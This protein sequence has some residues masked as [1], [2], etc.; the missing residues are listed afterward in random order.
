MAL[1]VHRSKAENRPVSARL[2]F[3]GAKAHKERM[4]ILSMTMLDN[5][6]AM[7]LQRLNAKIPVTTDK[8][9]NL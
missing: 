7:K 5:K 4:K 2:L 8:H 1:G 9:T 6:N 3:L